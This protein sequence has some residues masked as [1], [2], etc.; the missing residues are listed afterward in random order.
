MWRAPLKHLE[1]KSMRLRSFGFAFVFGLSI[2][3]CGSNDSADSDA[4]DGEEPGAGGTAGDDSGGGDSGNGG[5][6]SG[7]GGTSAGSGG[8]AGDSGGSGGTAGGGV[9]GAGG[10]F[11]ACDA[12][13]AWPDPEPATEPFRL[14]SGA[15]LPIGVTSDG[16]VVHRTG[17]IIYAARA[18][19]DAQPIEI[20]RLPGKTVVNGAF[21]FHWEN[22]DYTTG[23]GDLL[24]WSAPGCG[25]PLGNTLISEDLIQVS[26]S[27]RYVLHVMNVTETTLD[28]AVANRDFSERHVLVSGA[29]RASETTWC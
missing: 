1:A 28:I 15:G 13:A 5:D 16:Y 27:G 25:R 26:D 9:A 11:D 17:G 12:P 10:T 8:S 7:S 19:N 6:D 24:V 2:L 18:Q 23:L 29:G 3:A 14:D 4:D 22:L 21:V 20:S